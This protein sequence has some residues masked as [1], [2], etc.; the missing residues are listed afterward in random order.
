MLWGMIM[1]LIKCPECDGMVDDSLTACSLCGYPFEKK[2]NKNTLKEIKKCRNGQKL[3][4]Y[5]PIVLVIVLIVVI[6]LVIYKNSATQKY[7][8]E[9]RYFYEQ[10]QM[11]LENSN[12]AEKF[13]SVEFDK[14]SMDIFLNTY[15]DISL[16]AICLDE[17]VK[18]L[19][20]S[21]ALDNSYERLN[22]L[23]VEK[24][25]LNEI[26][27]NI[28][29]MYLKYKELRELLFNPGDNATFERRYSEYIEY[30]ENSNTELYEYVRN[31]RSASHNDENAATTDDN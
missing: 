31:I 18:T 15:R 7:K 6:G 9:A 11:I 16:S 10:M 30:F 13:S 8:R 19:S 27:Q 23:Y 26:K 3:K 14:D 24:K 29:S 12:A 5:L 22:R 28:D 20:Y 4:N 25:S 1:A 21:K 2:D 17:S